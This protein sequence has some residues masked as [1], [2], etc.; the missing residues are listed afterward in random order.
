MKFTEEQKRLQSVFR[1]PKASKSS[2][3]GTDPERG[4]NGRKLQQF[5]PRKT[6]KKSRK[7]CKNCK[8]RHI[9]CDEEPG[10]C[11]RCR[12]HGIECDYLLSTSDDPSQAVRTADEPDPSATEQSTPQSQSAM[13]STVVK[14]AAHRQDALAP[15]SCQISASPLSSISSSPGTS[16]HE[17]QALVHHF[18]TVT[19]MT[20]G[21][22]ASQA[23]NQSAVIAAAI[24]TPYL[25]HAL[26]GLATAHMRYLTARNQAEVRTRLK[27]V[28]CFY[29]AQAFEGFRRELAGPS[30]SCN[31]VATRRSNV[32]RHNM[33]QLLSTLMLVSMHQFSYRDYERDESGP[34]DKSFIWLEDRSQRD[35]ALKWLGI[36]A[37]FKGMIGAMAPWL[38]QSFWL[39][40]MRTVDADEADLKAWLLGSELDNTEQA[41]AKICGIG[42]NSDRSNPY[43]VNLETLIWCRRFQPIGPEH[44]NNMIAFVARTKAEFRELVV[45]RDTPA[46]LV[47]LHW[48]QLMHDIGQWWIVERCQAEIRAIVTFLLRRDVHGCGNQQ[49]L[50]LLEKPAEA[51]GMNITFYKD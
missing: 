26:L 44:F 24:E 40:I 11:L 20:C 1:V 6:H 8:E 43:Y 47:L 48:L 39:P 17:S 31:I 28:E 23:I 22:P 34:A 37:G 7:G 51:I 18:H 30:E 16:L 5:R 36:E 33:D 50:E 21:S 3:T 15:F 27:I 46:L 9:R 45:D 12:K 14:S 4:A 25:L 2:V 42:E 32:T 49:V 38:G 41:L 10:G 35:A 13:P 19:A 29:W